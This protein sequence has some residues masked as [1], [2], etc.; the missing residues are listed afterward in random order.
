ME[1]EKDVDT[2]LESLG[3][4]LREAVA[5]GERIQIR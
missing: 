2:F 5:N 3:K 1:T 4:Q